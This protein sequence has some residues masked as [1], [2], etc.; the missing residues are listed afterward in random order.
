MEDNVNIEFD[1]VLMDII[2]ERRSVRSFNGRKIPKEDILS[3][4]EA[5][6]WAPT[7]CN[8]QE[9]RF[10]I[11]DKED[12][13]NE[14]VQF[15]SFFKGVSTIILISSILPIKTSGILLFVVVWRIKGLGFLSIISSI[16]ALSG[17]NFFEN[18]RFSI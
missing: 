18:S 6:S 13:I 10:Y 4:I 1:K 12:E 14:I 11:L 17:N 8:N 2:K 3:I 9:L 15:K 16:L 5:G 7:G